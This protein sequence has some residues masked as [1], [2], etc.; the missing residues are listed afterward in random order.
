[1]PSVSESISFLINKLNETHRDS[2]ALAEIVEMNLNQFAM[3]M[4]FNEY[5]IICWINFIDRFNFFDFFKD[6]NNFD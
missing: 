5:E 2:V 6:F 4:L 3:Q 1:M